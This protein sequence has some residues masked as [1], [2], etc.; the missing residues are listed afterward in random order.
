M[1]EIETN[2][3]LVAKLA[4]PIFILVSVGSLVIWAWIGRREAALINPEIYP[5]FRR[6]E[7]EATLYVERKLVNIEEYER[8]KNVVDHML[9]YPPH[10][11]ESAE[12]YYKFLTRLGFQLPPFKLEKP[13]SKAQTEKCMKEAERLEQLQEK[14]LEGQLTKL[15][16]EIEQL[17]KKT[18]E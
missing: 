18:S 8:Y 16:R 14:V 5:A 10:V 9:K 13:A 17:I 7:L 11:S 6:V 15:E 3:S 2:N 1:N 12:E 4:I